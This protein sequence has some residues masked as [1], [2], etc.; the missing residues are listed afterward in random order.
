MF[1]SPVLY[2]SMTRVLILCLAV[3]R[4]NSH[5]L[6]AWLSRQGRGGDRLRLAIVTGV[7]QGLPWLRDQNALPGLIMPA[8]SGRPA[9][10]GQP[11]RTVRAGGRAAKPVGMVGR[12]YKLSCYRAA[13]RTHLAK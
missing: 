11:S 8:G 2:T 7:L 9:G 10:L 6:C 12:C 3:A 4:R 5:E 13:R 1:Q